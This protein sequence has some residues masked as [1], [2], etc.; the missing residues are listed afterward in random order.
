[1][2]PGNTEISD[3]VTVLVFKDNYS[4]RT[5]QVPLRWI[6]KFGLF[7]SI[8]IG[9]TA[10]SAFLA[11]KYYRIAS[12]SDP[13][14]VQ[15]LEQELTDLRIN[16][17]NLES[18]AVETTQHVTTSNNAAS[19]SVG[20][21]STAN[22]EN[23]DRKKS[24]PSQISSN[25]LP[26]FTAFS[27]SVQT[28]IP[29]PS[30]IPISILSP[31][32]K[33]RGSTLRVQFALQ[34]SRSDGS[35]QEGK[36]LILARGPESL[37]SYPSGTVNK[38]GTENLLSPEKGEPFSVSRY[39]EVKANFG[40]VRFRSDIQEIE[41]LLFN[42]EGQILAYQKVASESQPPSKAHEEE[43]QVSSEIPSDVSPK[44]NAEPKPETK[45]EAKPVTVPVTPPVT[46]V[47]KP[48]QK[49][50]AAPA[51][52]PTNPLTSGTPSTPNSKQGIS[53]P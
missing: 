6:S 27:S 41:I 24:A 40:P 47:E 18:K 45:L 1:M 25:Q 49:P 17:K 16:L 30:S 19:Q 22:S 33:W 36:I 8:L 14:H 28:Q 12:R 23:P 38:V 13:T 37:L 48:D 43:T 2:N 52:P 29:D 50:V 53:T 15:E 3:K 10:I 35:N 7:L 46:T 39:R 42:K 31:K 34:Y 4:A 51:T 32:L 11:I 20:P 26:V 9:V 44:T 21:N 5:F